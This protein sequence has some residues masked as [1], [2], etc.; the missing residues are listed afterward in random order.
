MT[1]DA[2]AFN[3]HRLSFGHVAEHYDRAR[4][5]YPAEAVTW[6]VGPEPGRVLDLGAG[7]GKL[8]RVAVD[9]GLEVVAV[10]PDPGMRA[11]FDAATPGLTARGEVSLGGPGERRSRRDSSLRALAGSAEEIP[12]PDA[13]VDAVIVGQAYH[14]FDRDKA[15]PEIARVLRPG[16]KFAPI[17][18]TRSVEEGWTKQLDEIMDSDRDKR[19]WSRVKDPDFGSLFGPIEDRVFHHTVVYTRERLRDM[20][21]SRSH[22]L[23]APP[24]RQADVLARLDALPG[25][26]FEMPYSTLV[27]KAFKR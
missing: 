24:E 25:D 5:T 14:W 20:V 4:P 9:L 27:R 8:T 15:L 2:Q 21:T 23:V 3:T 22:F 1:F 26:V 7:T 13:S 18:N 11:Q 12:L 16:G 19:W 17:W 6:A 10:E